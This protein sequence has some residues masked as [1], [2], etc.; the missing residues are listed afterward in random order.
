MAAIHD[1]AKLA[2]YVATTG[3][4]LAE[5]QTH[6]K[7][8]AEQQQKLAAQAPALA[9]S[10]VQAGLIASTQ[11]AAAV[12]QLSDPAALQQIL[13]NVV[14]HQQ[15]QAAAQ[16]PTS[17]GAGVPTNGAY[18]KQASASDP[19]D[20]GSADGLFVCGAARHMDDPVIARRSGALYKLAG[21][22]SR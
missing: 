20:A 19:G 1:P 18:S 8:A 7:Q 16:P 14:A 4:A 2:N 6:I 11:K 13:A 12:A 15:K 22:A 21:I 5:A 9:D 17:I 3:K 10:L